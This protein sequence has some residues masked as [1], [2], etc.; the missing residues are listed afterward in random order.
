MSGG[1][2]V[3]RQAEWAQALALLRGGGWLSVAGEPGIGK[4]RLL[5]ELAAEAGRRGHLVLT[6]RG[7]ELEREVPF[8]LWVDALDT[9][10]PA[11]V[12]PIAA[13]ESFR[14]HRAVR[15]LLEELAADRPVLVVLDDV[16]RADPASVDLLAHLARRPPAGSVLVAVAFRAGRAPAGLDDAVG[17]PSTALTLAPL[18]VG[19]AE[20]L[21][22][23]PVSERCWLESGGVPFYLE[24]LAR[25]GARPEGALDELEVPLPVR[26]ALA[27]EIA[28]L[29]GPARLLVQ[30]AAVVGDPVE[31]GL[32]AAAAGLGAPA[33]LAALDELLAADLLRADAPTHGYRFRHPIVR[34]AVYTSSGRGWRIAAH[35]RAA[36]ATAHEPT[37]AA[38][39][40][41]VESSALPGDVDAVWVLL[42]AAANAARSAPAAAVGWYRSALRLVPAGWPGRA[43]M[44]AVLGST[45]VAAGCLEEGHRAMADAVE[46][47]PVGQRTALVAAC[48][49]VEQLLG[50]H[51]AAHRRL[52]R[53]LVGLGG[54]EPAQAAL[55]QVEL[56]VDAAHHGDLPAVRSWAGEAWATTGRCDEPPLAAVAASLRSY[57]ELCAG[58]PA[59]VHRAQAVEAVDGCSDTQLAARPDAA[60][61]LAFGEYFGERYDDAVAHFRRGIAVCGAYGRDPFLVPMRAGLAFALEARGELAQAAEVADAAMESARLSGMAPL[62]GWASSVRAWVAASAAETSRAVEL[63]EE[64]AGLLRPTDTGTLRSAALA[65]LGAIQ[66]EAGDPHR[67]VSLLEAAGAPGFTLFAANRRFLWYAC[68]ARAELMRGRRDV[69]DGWVRRAEATVAGTEL[70]VARAFVLAAGAE[71]LLHDGAAA[72]AAERALLA[73]ELAAS[74]GARIE[75]ARARTLAG[76]PLAA[77]GDQPRAAAEL[78]VAEAELAGCG[79]LRYRD[80]AAAELRR[81]GRAVAPRGRS[82]QP[83]AVGLDALTGREREIAGLVAEG[84]TNRQVARA[85]FLSEKTVE[86]CLTQIFARLGIRSR[87]ALASAVTRAGVP[88]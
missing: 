19:A 78:A 17:A 44:T 39:A 2:L 71:L 85:L 36:A 63:G 8:G 42:A 68:L 72:A 20:E 88:A 80:H 9:G 41:H 65:H 55:L 3:G 61:Y 82:G 15:V 18:T 59:T 32:A 50:R 66:L 67:C 76:R 28:E 27:R 11:G 60:M 56:A 83:G 38:H 77:A 75:A 13:T 87:S 24:E 35:G 69:A 4:S 7:S 86:G 74:R 49:N 25:A 47:L 33:A 73:A 29:D 84:C 54:D 37:S 81:L 58:E 70:P 23:G 46:L 10:L 16:H 14:V 34:R 64:A 5:A 6:G 21:L 40:R 31:L 26:A 30:G 12:L 45:L 51:G 79:A 53:E 62:L 43:E 1:P 52:R 22:G 57:S 48:A